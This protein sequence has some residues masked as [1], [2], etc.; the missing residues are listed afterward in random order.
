[1]LLHENEKK[2]LF[3]KVEYEFVLIQLKLK[4]IVI[5]K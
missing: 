2:F 1:M 4:K 3:K 5:P